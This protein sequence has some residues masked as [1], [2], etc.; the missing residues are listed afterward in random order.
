MIPR[1]RYRRPALGG[2]L[3]LRFRSSLWT[4]ALQVTPSGHGSTQVTALAAETSG[5]PDS[6][7]RLRPTSG[8]FRC[9]SPSGSPPAS[10]PLGTFRT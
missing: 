5:R 10:E 6:T 8:T 4:P 7:E 3:L 1:V 2:L 9:S